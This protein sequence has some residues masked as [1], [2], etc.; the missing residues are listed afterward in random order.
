M[1]FDSFKNTQFSGPLM[2]LL[3]KT[4]INEDI[5]WK[6]TGSTYIYQLKPD[7]YFSKGGPKISKVSHHHMK[8]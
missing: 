7:G 1:V 5:H 3:K 8:K 6:A 4:G 2:K